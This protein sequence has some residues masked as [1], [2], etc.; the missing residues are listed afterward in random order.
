M[1]ESGCLGFDF[2]KPATSQHF[3]I[4]FL[5][6]EHERK[7]SLEKIIRSVFSAMD[8]NKKKRH[9]GVLHANKEHPETRMKVLNQLRAKPV[10]V[11]VIR[12]NKKKVYTH[13]QDEKAVLYNY[14]TNILLDRLI[15]KRILPEGPIKFIASRR[16]T[17]K[18]LNDNFK[19]YLHQQ[20]S[21]KLDIEI[22]I[23][24]PAH[25][26]C[27]QVVDFISWSVFRHYEHRDDT[28]HKIIK[29]LIIEDKSLF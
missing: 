4:T 10:H 12:L 7:R 27:L 26:K 29:G 2:T 23:H 9:C 17:N 11:M 19:K 8:K 21:G 20:V 24:T 28:Y 22:L 6:V 13:L 14:V 15:S 16:E 3:V 25:E 1:D 18:F 5:F